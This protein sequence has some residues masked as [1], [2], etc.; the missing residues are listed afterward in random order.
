MIAGANPDYH[1]L[2]G[3][4]LQR[5]GDH[6]RSAGAYRAALDTQAGNAQAWIGLG[7]S[8]EAL[9]QRPEAAEAFRRALVAGLGN[10]DLR[11]FAEQRIRALR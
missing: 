3:A 2:H 5:A 4:V 6:G 9:K 8:L 1:L 7:I 10:D 11:Q